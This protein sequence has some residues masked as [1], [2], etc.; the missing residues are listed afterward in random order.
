VLADAAMCVMES[1]AAKAGA[2]REWL[3]LAAV[4]IS[5]GDAASGV[6]QPAVQDPNNPPEQQVR[7]RASMKRHDG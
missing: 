7:L 1:D 4:E 6:D 5:A 3:S 2:V